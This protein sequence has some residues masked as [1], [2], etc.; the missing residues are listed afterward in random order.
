[1]AK[2]KLTALEILISRTTDAGD[3]CILWSGAVRKGYG[4]LKVGKVVMDAHVVALEFHK[5]EKPDPT[6]LAGHDCG[7]RSCCNPKHLNWISPIEN[8][9]HE[10]EHERTGIRGPQAARRIRALRACKAFRTE[11]LTRAEIQRKHREIKRQ[12]IECRTKG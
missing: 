11:P 3:E 2:K 10:Y 9:E 1:M 5:G 6:Y 7:I 8:R 4:A 12:R